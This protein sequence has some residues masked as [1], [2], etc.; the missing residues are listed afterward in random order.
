MINFGVYT[1]LFRKLGMAKLLI[2]QE[3]EL[4]VIWGKTSIAA[5]AEK[6]C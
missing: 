2:Q 5:K 1:T 4:E 6:I 3:R